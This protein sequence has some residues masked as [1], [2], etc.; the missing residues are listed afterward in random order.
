MP[1]DAIRVRYVTEF[2]RLSLWYVDKILREGEPD[3]ARAVNLRVNIYRNTSL[4]D[5]QNHPAHQDVGPAWA[6][7]LDRLKGIYDRRR[8]DPSAEGFEAEGLALL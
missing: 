4:Y 7:V 8:D 6:E 3:F 5:G 1:S 2:T